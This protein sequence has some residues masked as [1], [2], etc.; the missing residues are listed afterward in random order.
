MAL[1]AVAGSVAAASSTPKLKTAGSQAHGLARPMAGEATPAALLGDLLTYDYDNTRSGRDMVDP[2][3]KNLSSAPVWDDHAL[4]GAV[5]GEPLVYDATVYV[6]TENDT[7]YAIAAATGK[8]LWHQHVGTAVSTSVVDSAPTLGSGCGDIDPLGITGTP[9]IDAATSE[10]FVAEETEMPGASGWEGIRHWL[11][12][13]SLTTH[14][15]LWHR[16][17]DPPGGNNSSVYYIPAEQQ[18]PAITLANGRLYVDFGGLDGD[19][20]QYHGYVVDLPISGS[21]SL[22]SYQVPTQ[23]EGAVWETNGAVVSPQGDLYV[24]TG[25]GSSN[26]ISHFDEG[27]AVV[28]LAPSLRRIGYW[29]PSNWVELNDQD[30]DL[31]S[32][33]PIAV[34]GTSLLFVAGK[35]SS[36]G[37][38]GYLV[39]EG[40]LA[41]IGHGAYTGLACP[42]G[43]AFGADA[44]DVV[45]SRI[46]IYVPC[47][48]GTE[49]LQITTSPMSFRRVWAPSTG[50]PNG[51]PVVAGGLVWALDWNNAL[52]YGMNPVSGLVVVRRST[53]SLEHFVA[54]GVG[55]KMLF[56]PTAYGLEAFRTIG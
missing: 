55:D 33:G 40:H 9:V 28:E 10:I 14:K 32:A 49:A 50:S 8:V 11:V 21:G 17:I 44:S 30:W 24:A 54:P 20:G 51:S 45:G 34:P 38:Y 39:R 7:V 53:D 48:S 56:V 29:A 3:I 6:A 46:F 23:R 41:G 25:N 2:A 15:V 43:G 52:L 37:D 5:Y 1:V 35:P 16:D 22:A 4:D 18:R 42:G 27:N 47:G 13:I 12:A 19:C 26:L 31:G 36:S